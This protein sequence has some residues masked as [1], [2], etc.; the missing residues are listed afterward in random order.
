MTSTRIVFCRLQ[1]FKCNDRMCKTVKYAQLGGGRKAHTHTPKQYVRKKV[2]RREKK[3]QRRNMWSDAERSKN[4]R[5]PRRT[6][7]MKSKM[8]VCVA[9]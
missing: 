4:K 5:L 6:P 8:C 3:K 2:P 9:F 1:M 7:E